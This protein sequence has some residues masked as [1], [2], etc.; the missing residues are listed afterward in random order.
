MAYWWVN[1]G[2][3]YKEEVTGFMW[4]PQKN[5]NDSRSVSYDNMLLIQPGDVIFAHSK[6]LIRAIGIATSRAQHSPKPNFGK[7]GLNWLDDGWLVEVDFTELIDPIDVRE[8]MEKIRPN[9]PNK[10]SPLQM[11]GNAVQAYLFSLPEPMASVLASIRPTEFQAV[12]SRPSKY[13]DEDFDIENSVSAIEMRFDISATEKIQLA[14]SRR[15]Q[16]LFKANVRLVESACRVTGVSQLSMLR[17]SHI[18]PWRDAN[19]VEKIDGFNGLLLAPHV[20]HLFDKGFITF[21]DKGQMELSPA[22][23]VEILKR[24]G[25]PQ[26]LNVG[27]FC[28][29]QKYYLAHHHENIFIA[30]A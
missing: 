12:T 10:H 8:H 17:A 7:A 4:S 9:L 30:T 28:D 5:K 13:T 6:K 18:K 3:T 26:V 11:N 14:K 23:N 24:W 27:D 19:D 21:E 20:D 22:L 16:G 15:G 25:I 2:S 29:E 1:L